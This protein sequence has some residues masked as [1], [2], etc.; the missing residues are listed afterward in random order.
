[1]AEKKDEEAGK[2]ATGHQRERKIRRE[3][4]GGNMKK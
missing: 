3:R 4:G 2:K 1:M